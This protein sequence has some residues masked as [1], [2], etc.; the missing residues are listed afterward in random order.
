MVWL[1]KFWNNP[2]RAVAITSSGVTYLLAT[3]S[4]IAEIVLRR[5]DML[6]NAQPWAEDGKIFIEQQLSSGLNAWV[7]TYAGYF[8]IIP[9]MVTWITFYL[10]TWSGAGILYMP[11]L[12]NLS[13]I[14]IA[15]FTISVVCL[16]RFQW[17][18]S[19][20][21]RV[22]IAMGVALAPY[23][24]EIFGNITNVQWWF[25]Y[26]D[27]LC[28]MDLIVTKRMPNGWMILVLALSSLSG[29]MG[30]LPA[31]AVA[32]LFMRNIPG[33]S[34]IDW[35]KVFAVGAGSAIEIITAFTQRSQPIHQPVSLFM[36]EFPRVFFSIPAHMVV[37]NFNFF[38]NTMH[39]KGAMIIG[40]VVLV[41]LFVTIRGTGSKLFWASIGY[42]STL[43]LLTYLGSASWFE[44]YLNYPY[45]DVGGR[46]LF[47]PVSI[48]MTL[49]LVS[50]SKAMN[51]GPRSILGVIV[52]LATI[53][54]V[55]N[56]SI[57]PFVNDNW[58]GF[59][60][61]YVEDGT[62][63]ISIP[64]NPSWSMSIPTR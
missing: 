45:G 6:L 23:S 52:L 44:T 4:V 20:P 15:S 36:I 56:F 14:V 55:R 31:A 42:L 21:W 57:P 53:T 29:P 27:F 24:P 64:I 58:A 51:F 43:L 40:L 30:M 16:P 19:V 10:S 35:L 12:M 41:C 7:T 5:P 60:K 63:S 9:R 13:A 17:M 2:S 8:H 18:A 59:A 26:F 37:P 25:G 50:I 32:I 47:V 3:F 54:D 22:A 49:T 39:F 61:H 28:T 48:V 34:M 46:Y 11:V 33:R 62:H 38:I 1:T